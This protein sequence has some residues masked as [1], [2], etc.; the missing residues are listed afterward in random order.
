MKHYFRFLL[1]GALATAVCS[2][3]AD[4]EIVQ[5]VGPQPNEEQAITMVMENESESRALFTGQ[6]GEG[7][8][9]LSF[10][11][12]DDMVLWEVASV[13]SKNYYHVRKHSS[14]SQEINGDKSKATFTYNVASPYKVGETYPGVNTLTTDKVFYTGILPA[15][16]FA[17]FYSNTVKPVDPSVTDYDDTFMRLN[18]PREQNPTAT[19][20]D[21]NAIILRAYDSELG[22]D[23]VINTRFMHMLAYLKIT[24][25][26]LPVDFSMTKL[27]LS[28]LPLCNANPDAGKTDYYCQFGFHFGFENSNVYGK[29]GTPLAI[30]TDQLEKD[31]NGCYTVWAACIPYAR[32][33]VQNLII[34][35]YKANNDYV[36]SKLSGKSIPV[37]KEGGTV[38]VDGTPTRTIA[39]KAGQVTALTLNFGYGNDLTAPVVN[40]STTTIDA[41]RSSVTFSWPVNDQADHYCYT[42]NGGEEQTT[43]NNFVA[44]TA[45]PNSEV[46]IKVKSC[47]ADD[48]GLVASGWTTKTITAAPY[49]EP[50]VWGEIEIASENSY[51]V[52]LTWEPIEHAVSYA[53]KFGESGQVSY[54]SPA[55]DKLYTF[56]DLAES[57]TYIVYLQALPA[58]GSTTHK[59]SEWKDYTIATTAKTPLTMSTPTV[60]ATGTSSATLVWTA[61]E[62]AAGYSYKVG[63]SGAEVEIGNVTEYQ[64]TGLTHST[65]HTIY[66]RALGAANTDN[67]NSEWVSVEATTAAATPLVMGTVTL[68]TITDTAVTLTWDA[69]AN[70]VGYRYQL[71]DGTEG[72]AESGVAIKGLTAETA[73][74]IKI[75]AVAQAD[76]DY[77][78]SEWSDAIAFTTTE[79]TGPLNAWGSEAFAELASQTD[80][81]GNLNDD[82]TFGGLTF[83]KGSGN[84]W[85]VVTENGIT[86]LESQGNADGGKNYLSF[87]ATGNGTL[88]I[89]GYNAHSK[90]KALHIYV[91]SDQQHEV[92]LTAESNYTKSFAITASN[93]DTVKICPREKF[94]RIYSIAWTPTE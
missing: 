14:T 47:P 66:M 89:E 93:G 56:S 34:T 13:T 63:E 83:T 72:T 35:P 45:T 12:G 52:T 70:A 64:I 23:G 26:G 25:K 71:N 60:T 88:T 38:D 85:K 17:G 86:Y 24:V 81:N 41:E 8:W 30:Y 57:T 1:A 49:Y 75:K 39:L 29:S 53:Y 67:G 28:G 11:E 27:Q 22:A 51:S 16:A 78:D 46:T 2:C 37:S 10:S 32:S 7:D 36:G 19:S 15:S 91:N 42:I 54:L 79:A 80:G 5:P 76:S 73:Y 18:I 50:L 62:G 65:T 20:P 90:N 48:S 6:N 87:V 69:V 58:D 59:A 55:Q 92:T 61:V 21:P 31:A 44:L 43:T 9:L 74:T 94:N 4:K 40:A 84:G 68:G 77:A 33:T 82:A 3:S